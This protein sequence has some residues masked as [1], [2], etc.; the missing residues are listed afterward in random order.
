MDGGGG[1]G[2]GMSQT[3]HVVCCY[4]VSVLLYVYILTLG[5]KGDGG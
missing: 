3:Q 1:G 4:K 5:T 2:G